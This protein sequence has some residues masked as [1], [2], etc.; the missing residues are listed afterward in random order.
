MLFCNYRYEIL[1]SIKKQLKLKSNLPIFKHTRMFKYRIYGTFGN[2][3][4]QKT[5]LGTSTS[6][7]STGA[8]KPKACLP[9]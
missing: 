4:D 8:S 3:E 7:T 9:K 5:R 1:Q 2:D 6:G